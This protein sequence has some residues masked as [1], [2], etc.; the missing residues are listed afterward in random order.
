MTDSSSQ[1]AVQTAPAEISSLDFECLDRL[2]SNRF[3]CRGYLPDQV[4]RSTIEQVLALAQKSASWCN[5]QPW[6]T[7][8]TEGQATIDFREALYKYAVGLDW[9][10]QTQR[11]EQPDFP[12]PARYVGIYKDRQRATGWALYQSVGVTMGDRVASGK[13]MLQNF[14]IFGAPHMMLVT[15]EDDL[16]V[17]GAVDCGAYVAHVMLAF[18]ALGIGCIAQ[19]AL[20]GVAPFVRDWFDIPPNRKIVCAVSFGYADHSHPANGFRTGREDYRRTVQFVSE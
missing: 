2:V 15:T 18:Q 6:G 7:I 11:L 20:A 10:D 16:G 14:R 9:G 5:S 17:Y 4:P 19:A 1:E 3:S 13:Q 12:F 8:I